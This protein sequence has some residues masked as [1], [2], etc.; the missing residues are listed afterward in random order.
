M[1]SGE[2]QKTWAKLAPDSEGLSEQEIPRYSFPQEKPSDF[3]IFTDASQQAYGYILYAK[4]L[5][6]SNFVTTKCKT[7]TLIKI[8]L[9]ILELL[10]VYLGLMGMV[11][12]LNIYKS[13]NTD[14][15]AVACDSQVVIQWIL[16][17][18]VKCNKK[19]FVA[20]R[21]KDIKRFEAEILYD[22]NIQ[23]NYKVKK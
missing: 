21:L 2:F 17:D 13:F 19:V 11:K 5:N 1:I 15:I 3:I 10:G 23:M 9:P 18:P 20:N 8:T 22:Y 12:C 4:Q 16:S 7:A 14:N 6:I